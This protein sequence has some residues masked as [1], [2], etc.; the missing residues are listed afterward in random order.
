MHKRGAMEEE[1]ENQNSSTPRI[2]ASG[3]LLHLGASKV[4]RNLCL[5]HLQVSILSQIKLF[6]EDRGSFC[7]IRLNH[8]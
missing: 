1:L 3:D 8:T 6:P 2:P 4:I 5:S 7:S